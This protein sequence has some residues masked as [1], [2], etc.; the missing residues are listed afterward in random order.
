M[1]NAVMS[2]LSAHSPDANRTRALEMLRRLEGEYGRPAWRPS[3]RPLDELVS[4]I[5]SQ[6]TSDANCE[7]AFESLRRMFPTWEH[8]AQASEESI[9]D[10]IRG[11]GLA[12]MK[13]PRIKAVVREALATGITETLDNLT[14]DDA[15]SRL[16]A[17]PGVGPKTVACVLLF[18]CGRPALPVDTHVYRVSRRVGLIDSSISV[19]RAHDA[20]EA[21]LPPDD[22]YSFHIN[23]IRL[24][25][26]IC[27]ARIPRCSICVLASICD[28]ARAN[29]PADAHAA[30]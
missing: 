27:K 21:M 14:L 7:R 3:G 4:T 18:A 22:V 15:K 29:Y 19:D 25:R 24:G 13:A 30:N 8:V 16:R 1:Y 26:E 2:T 5:L 17:L 20:L 10:A 28:Y 9:A 11:G 12:T 23:V 6:H